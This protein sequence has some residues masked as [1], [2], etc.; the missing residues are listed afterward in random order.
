MA[1]LPCAGFAADGRQ[2]P[3]VI[4]RTLP[5]FI[6]PESHSLDKDM[7]KPLKELPS[8][9]EVVRRSEIVATLSKITFSGATVTDPVVLDR[10]VAPYLNRPIT[11]ADIASL[12]Y[13][14]TKL[15]YDNGYILIK[16]VTPPQDLSDGILDITIVEA[17]VGDIHINTNNVLQ[18]D[19]ADAIASRIESGDVFREHSV[20]S[21]ASD[22]DDLKGLY[23]TVKLVP[24]KEFAT[25]DLE[26]A[27]QAQEE[28]TH[29]VRIDN[30]GSKY[31]GRNVATAHVEESN[32]LHLGETFDATARI[33]DGALWSVNIGAF[34]P[35]GLKNIKAEFDYTHGEQRINKDYTTPGVR[36]R[37][38]TNIV[39]LGLSSD[40]IN[41]RTHKATIRSGLELRRH[42]SILNRTL[43]SEDDIRQAFLQTSYLYRS[44]G[45][46]WYGAVKLSQGLKILGADQ[47]GDANLSRPLGDPQAF[48]AEPLMLANFRLFDSGTLKFVASG[49]F[50]SNVLLSSDLFI[51]GG[52]GSVRGFQPAQETG[53]SGFQFSTEY[54][55]DLDLHPDWFVGI[56]PWV[57]G[58]TVFNRLNASISGVQDTH[59]Y[60]AGVS[61]EAVT[62]LIP[63]GDTSFRFDW[64]HPLG[65]YDASDVNGDWFYFR[66]NQDF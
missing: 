46:V 18:P 63:R 11:R 51:L 14:I 23:S 47:E 55:H 9:E 19:M 12:K 20:E 10:I 48:R 66:V 61:L 3:G 24:G 58:G 64:A 1:L 57:D 26:V 5:E 7:K 27:I 40:I 53:E 17:R 8:M 36:Q 45:S 30:Y 56:G 28:D 33:S 54:L 35:V 59:L 34:M 6:V 52:Y 21:M 2:L 38:E 65:S 39:T 4:D 16:V 32:Q 29:Y 49:Q 44:P 31:T 62:E 60:S 13:D 37:G 43:S 22:L 15:F 41:T 50:S 25:T 42:E